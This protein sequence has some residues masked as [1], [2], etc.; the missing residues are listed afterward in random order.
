MNN[1]GEKSNIISIFLIFSKN[2][3]LKKKAIN[4]FYEIMI[5][6]LRFLYSIFILDILISNRKDWC[7]VYTKQKMKTT[8]H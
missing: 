7:L 5:C 3:I 4:M 2:L 1:F 6:I 8:F